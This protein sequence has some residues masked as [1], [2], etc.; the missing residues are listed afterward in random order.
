MFFEC[1]TEYLTLRKVPLEWQP[2]FCRGW[3]SSGS[4]EMR[5]SGA[6]PCPEEVPDSLW[7]R[8]LNIGHSLTLGATQSEK[9]CKALRL[10]WQQIDS[11]CQ[12]IG[13]TVPERVRV[14]AVL[15]RRWIG[16]WRESHGAHGSWAVLVPVL[17]LVRRSMSASK[18]ALARSRPDVIWRSRSRPRAAATIRVAATWGSS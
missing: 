8:P 16:G 3:L 7:G 1:G 10:Q 12:G 17:A 6:S 13:V 18:A 9:S 4:P 14:S 15:A 11:E 2:R 5:H